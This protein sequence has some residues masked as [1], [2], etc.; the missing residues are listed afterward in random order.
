[1][2]LQEILRTKATE[3]A[4]RIKEIRRYLHAHPELSL[5]ETGTAKLVADRLH[6]L[7]LQPQLMVGATGVTALITGDLPGRK[8]VALRA[9][10]DALPIVETTGLPYAS[11]NPGVMHACGHDGHTA[12]LL[13]AAELLLEVRSQ[14]GGHVKLIFQP[15]EEFGGGAH[16][17]IAEQVL[18]QPK[19]DAIFGLHGW[20]KIDVGA[21]GVRSGPM[22]AAS[23]NFTITVTGR[24]THAAYPQN[25]L[26]PISGLCRLVQD[27]ETIPATR[28]SA[29]ETAVVTV[30]S[31][32]AGGAANNVVPE[33]GTIQG[34]YRTL[35]DS[36]RLQIGDEIR[37]RA[38]AL[39]SLGY[40]VQVTLKAGNPVTMNSAALEAVVTRSLA[41][42][43]GSAR[44]MQITEP[45]MGAEDFAKYGAHVP[46]YFLL[47]G[48]GERPAL[49]NPG[50]DFNDDALSFGMQAFV[51][52]AVEF[53][54]ER[55]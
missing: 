11:Q 6:A 38:S 41:T 48:V 49:H 39:E 27:L 46:A 34:T 19:V 52:I 4:P 36:V 20:P 30:A 3:I 35:S 16:R 37:R 10:M 13:G 1:M 17:M 53:L 47:L 29:L 32:V 26:N 7:G 43:L 14:F 45:S 50:Y 23:D 25:G 8:T 54:A 51:R 55:S 5:H 12:N 24:G 18:E 44:V 15:A 42:Q 40:T 33:T 28:I 2:S 22:L 9:D 31:L 21:I